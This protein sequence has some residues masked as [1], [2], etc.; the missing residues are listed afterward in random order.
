MEESTQ[1]SRS[2]E[3]RVVDFPR[4]ILISKTS[5]VLRKDY[6]IYVRV[7]YRTRDAFSFPRICLKRNFGRSRFFLETRISSLST[8]IAIGHSTR[9]S[10]LSSMARI[11]PTNSTSEQRTSTSE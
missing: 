9:K 2:T 6:P 4:Q 8:L 7:S 3:L 10:R 11:T 5:L 1:P